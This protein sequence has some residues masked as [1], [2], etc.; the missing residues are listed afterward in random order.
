MTS[1]DRLRLAR[2]QRV[3]YRIIEE[4]GGA[5]DRANETISIQRQALTQMAQTI[6]RLRAELKAGQKNLS[7][8]S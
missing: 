8:N 3:A 5:L 1:A 4:Q 2:K 6:S 7:R